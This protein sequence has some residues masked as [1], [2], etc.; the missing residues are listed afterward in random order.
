MAR[1]GSGNLGSARRTEAAYL[2]EGNVLGGIGPPAQAHDKHVLSLGGL[3]EKFHRERQAIAEIIEQRGFS[4]R[5]ESY[6]A[7]LDGNAVDAS[8]LL[9]P[10]VGYKP[11]DDPR[12]VSTL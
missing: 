9:M 8:L 5:S 4:S 10:C 1:A 3:R 7:E 2:F 6:V 11:A 12:V